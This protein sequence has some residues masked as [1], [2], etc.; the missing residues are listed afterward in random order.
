MKLKEAQTA[1]KR[2]KEEIKIL[3]I[4]I[5]EKQLQ[6]NKKRE[7]IKSLEKRKPKD[8]TISEHAIL[9]FIE[10]GIG[11]DIKMIEDNLKKQLEKTIT[12][13]GSGEYPINGGFKA[14]V[15]DNVLLTIIPS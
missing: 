1:I 11:I 5:S 14:R 15:K 2:Y 3:G 8:L 13:L 7:A 6:I 10:R 4:E 9:R 12:E